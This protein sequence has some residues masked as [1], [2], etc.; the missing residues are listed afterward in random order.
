MLA[1]T[2]TPDEVYTVAVDRGRKM[3]TLGITIDFAPVVDVSDAPADTVIGDRSF[4][5]DPA[6]VTA[7]AGAY[8]R[9][10]R[11]A[12]LL[13]VLKHFP[14]HGHGSGDSH[15]GAV[16][17]PPLS[18]LQRDDLVP[19]RTLV[20]AGPV[21]VMIGHMQVPGLTGDQ[22]ASLSPAAVQLLRTGSGY[23]APPFDGPVFSDD[24]SSMAAIS[25]R[26]GVAEAVLRTLQAGTD[27]ALWV[28]TDE[29]PAVL[30]RLEKALAAGELT[31][32][33]VD[34]SVLRMAEVKGPNPAC[35]R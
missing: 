10:L 1:Q 12:G 33:A 34:K 32:P 20:T 31:M 25:D 2:K 29:V 27:T 4:G 19:Y 7:Y 22:P 21:G 26:F 15:T 5:S 8:A 28:T 35:G 23:G 30:D 18:E 14:G 3:R 24:L 11:D 13:P 9:G 17:T 16:T 6:V